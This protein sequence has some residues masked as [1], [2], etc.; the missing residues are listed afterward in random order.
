MRSEPRRFMATWNIRAGDVLMGATWIA[1]GL[2]PALDSAVPGPW[3][4]AYAGF[5]LLGAIGA[6]RW[7]SSY[8]EVD[9]DEVR[10]RGIVRRRRFNRRD[11]LDVVVSR[12]GLWQVPRVSLRGRRD[13]LVGFLAA[14]P[15]SS[16]GRAFDFASEVLVHES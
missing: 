11:V 12:E 3:R 14:P 7:A 2:F 10:I 1:V 9:Q 6:V 15:G 16:K 13:L 8:A 4:C 5:A